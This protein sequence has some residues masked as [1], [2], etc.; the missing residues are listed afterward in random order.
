MLGASAAGAPSAVKGSG[1]ASPAT[2]V[3][4]IPSPQAAADKPKTREGALALC[5]SDEAAWSSW[6][7]E[8]GHVRHDMIGEHVEQDQKCRLDALKLPTAH[9]YHTRR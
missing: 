9:D 3:Q 6:A 7:A 4:A 5:D 1:S 2:T 8:R